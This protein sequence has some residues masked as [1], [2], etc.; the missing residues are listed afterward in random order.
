MQTRERACS[1]SLQ[2]KISGNKNPILSSLPKHWHSLARQQFSALNLLITK[3]QQGAFIVS[4]LLVF[5]LKKKNI[6]AECKYFMC[7][8]HEAGLS[9]CRS[10]ISYKR[11]TEKDRRAEGNGILNV[12]VHTVPACVC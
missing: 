2:L 7:P 1:H 5:R 9:F 11:V 12:C 6:K 10:S 3:Q 4:H 8:G